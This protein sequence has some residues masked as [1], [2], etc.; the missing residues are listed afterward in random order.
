VVAMPIALTAVPLGATI[1]I[2]GIVV[3]ILII[4]LLLWIF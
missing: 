3:L 4:L 1:V 2:P